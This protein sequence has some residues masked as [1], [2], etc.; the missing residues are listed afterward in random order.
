MPKQKV[1]QAERQK[2]GQGAW[3]QLDRG[4]YQTNELT[5]LARNVTAVC[6]LSTPTSAA[7][8][9]VVQSEGRD[10]VGGT[11][12]NHPVTSHGNDPAL[13]DDMK[14]QIS[15]IIN[16]MKSPQEKSDADTETVDE[17]LIHETLIHD[18]LI[19]E[20]LI[21]E[22]LVHETLVHGTHHQGSNSSAVTAQLL[23]AASAL[24]LPSTAS[25]A[26]PSS[27]RSE[28]WELCQAYRPSARFMAACVWDGAMA[29]GSR[30]RSLASVCASQSQMLARM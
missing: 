29:A 3:A 10:L 1:A 4:I 17:T 26:P 25:I 15:R 22:T 9:P 28:A 18:S 20:T 11:Q 13:S 12:V 24:V 21:H 23:A 5:D 14:S 27:R 7:V 19:H 8:A 6:I 30:P 16:G 2:D